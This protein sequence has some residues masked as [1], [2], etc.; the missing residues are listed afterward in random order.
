MSVTVEEQEQEQQYAQNYLVSFA[1]LLGQRHAMAGQNLMPTITTPDEEAAFKAVVRNSVGAISR[2]QRW[3]ATFIT[4]MDS[5]GR[6][7][8][9]R[10]R[11]PEEMK[12]HWDLMRKSNI[13]S[14]HWSDGLVHF[15]GLGDKSVKCPMNGAFTLIAASAN[16][17]LQGLAAKSPVRCAVDVAWAIELRDGELYGPAVARAYELESNVAQYPR[18]VVG[19]HAVGYFQAQ[20]QRNENDFFAQYERQLG[21]LCL[22]LIVKDAD[23]SWIL[24][25]LGPVFRELVPAESFAELYKHALEF[26]KSQVQLHRKEGNSKLAFRYTMLLGYFEAHPL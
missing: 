17:C 23:G 24:H 19:D 13:K 1:D 2:L 3:A 8:K 18:V 15:V 4:S 25:Y 20:A 21:Q 7:S 9:L 10:D 16:H 22:D 12:A 14:Q 6:P 11:L 26:V 5:D